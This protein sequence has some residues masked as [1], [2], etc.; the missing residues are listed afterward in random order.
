VG[1][2]PTAHRA[3]FRERLGTAVSAVALVAI[4]VA[5]G[6][7]SRPTTT[8]PRSGGSDA[9][10]ASAAQ[11]ATPSAAA[12]VDPANAFKLVVVGTG[13]VEANARQ[14]VRTAKGIVYIFAADDTAQRTAS[15]PG[16]ARAWKG[17]VPGIP[18][19]FAE[20]DGAHRPTAGTPENV[21]VDVDARLD[22]SGI[23]HLVYVDETDTTLYYRTFSTIS[24]TWGPATALATGINVPDGFFERLK[25]SR[26]AVSIALDAKDVPRV[27]Y[28]S[29]GT[30]FYTDRSNGTWST[31]RVVSESRGP[32]HPQL[33]FG[34]DG[35][36]HLT[37]LENDADVPRVLY[38]RLPPRGDWQPPE[39]V[40]ASDVQDNATGDQGPSIAVTSSG[41]PY[42][43]WI[44]PRGTSGVR[45]KYRD[46]ATGQWIFDPLPANLY[47]HAPQIYTQ[48]NDIYAFLGHDSLIRFGY[49]YQLRGRGWGPYV[50]LT[51]EADGTLDGAASVRWD[52]L[53][54]TNRKVIDAAF[55]DE[56]IANDRTFLP[57]LYYMAVLP[58][59]TITTTR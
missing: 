39:V 37:W 53:H 47:T 57:R 8:L 54:E 38:S 1:V 21:I 29:W 26:G 59:R 24:D 49:E 46:R 50:P 55:F 16:V 12:A 34:R 17:N 6:A 35:T 18:T 10:S 22:R 19:A 52:P 4:L 14:V 30:I 41:V 48:G 13:Y 31:P 25:R 58:S 11:G 43:L 44:S 32:T 33:A 42:V 23:V 45:I 2:Q 36:L 40:D 20:V 56:D 9:E 27:V 15:G 5:G 28:C 51:T 3:R 7:W